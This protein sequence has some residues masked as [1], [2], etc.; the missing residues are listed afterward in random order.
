MRRDRHQVQ[1]GQGVRRCVAHRD[2]DQVQKGQGA[3][4]GHIGT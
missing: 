4:R 1:K 2:R 3:R